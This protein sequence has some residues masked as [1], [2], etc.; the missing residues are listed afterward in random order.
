MGGGAPFYRKKEALNGN[1]KPIDALRKGGRIQVVGHGRWN[2]QANK[3]EMS[4]LDASQLSNTLKTLPTDNT[5]D[6]IKR[7]SLVGCRL[8]DR[9]FS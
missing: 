9:Q 2:R 3:M 1:I 7:V 5:R 8:G 6:A 4:G